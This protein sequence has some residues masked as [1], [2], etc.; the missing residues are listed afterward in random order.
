MYRWKRSRLLGAVCPGQ[1]TGKVLM[2]IKHC[3]TVKNKEIFHRVF[4]PQS[5]MKW[6]FIPLSIL[7]CCISMSALV[8]ALIPKEYEATQVVNV[9][10]GK[11]TDPFDTFSID[12]IIDS[13]NQNSYRS[14]VAKTLH[15]SE[16]S[17]PRFRA[18]ATKSGG[19]MI[20]VNR[21]YDRE[22]ITKIFNL[23]ETIIREKFGEV[24]RSSVEFKKVCIDEKYD[25]IQALEKQANL[26]EERVNRLEKN[27]LNGQGKQ[28]EGD[29]ASPLTLSIIIDSQTK[30]IWG[31]KLKIMEMK[32]EIVTLKSQL[33]VID[34]ALEFQPVYVDGDVHSKTS[35][36]LFLGF[37]FGLALC[38][39]FISVAIILQNIR[40]QNS[41]K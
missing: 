33:S 13:I 8:A 19:M 22:V 7:F 6:K 25:N 11:Y 20:V 40:M 24:T 10:K 36:I 12:L 30:I 16:R 28:I 3:A 2:E 17:L 38:I 29:S 4:F 37:A 9:Y 39:T 27:F 41:D 32:N 18:S 26:A 35:F 15:V 21:V 1:Q 23:L 5:L 31:N 34:S 14:F